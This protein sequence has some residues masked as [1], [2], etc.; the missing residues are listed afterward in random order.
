MSTP[1]CRLLPSSSSLHGFA[2][3]SLP[4]H[5]S[6]PSLSQEFLYRS[7]CISSLS[8]SFSKIFIRLVL[9][10]KTFNSFSP[11]T[12]SVNFSL[13]SKTLHNLVWHMLLLDLDEPLLTLPN[14]PLPLPLI[15]TFLSTLCPQSP[16]F[17]SLGSFRFQNSLRPS[18]NLTFFIKFP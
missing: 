9:C 10:S 2:L 18:S 14:L 11:L 6:R 4:Q 5:L 12:S 13:N 16:C 8:H 1:L 3:S 15:M 17:Y 7:I